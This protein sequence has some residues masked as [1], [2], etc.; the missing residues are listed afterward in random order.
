MKYFRHAGEITDWMD[1]RKAVYYT[2]GDERWLA[3][4]LKWQRLFGPSES[5]DLI[6][7]IAK[8]PPGEI[9]LPHHHPD[10]PELYY[11]LEGQGLFRVAGEEK[12]CGPGSGIY[13]PAGASH[14]VWNNGTEELVFFFAYDRPFYQTVLDLGDGK[15][16]SLWASTE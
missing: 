16:D 13:M 11:V 5:E 10:A 3:D 6:F 8:L 12:E 7:G 15:P 1:T 9:H 4:K 14:S 2:G